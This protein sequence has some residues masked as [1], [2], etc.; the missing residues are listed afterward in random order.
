MYVQGGKKRRRQGLGLEDFVL[1]VKA[2]E[3]YSTG[4]VESVHEK[5]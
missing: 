3:T 1:R 4:S 5:V 2:S